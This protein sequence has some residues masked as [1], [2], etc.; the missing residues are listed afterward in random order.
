[1]HLDWRGPV[2][3]VSPHPPDI[4]PG[5]A[6]RLYRWQPYEPQGEGG[7]AP[8]PETEISPYTLPGSDKDW[9]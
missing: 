6:P 5:G 1:L 4:E 3:I 9:R 7:H 8:A 2:P